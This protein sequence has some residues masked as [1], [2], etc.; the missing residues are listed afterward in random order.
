MKISRGTGK[1]EASVVDVRATHQKVMLKVWIEDEVGRFESAAW[2][3]IPLKTAQNMVRWIE[4]EIESEA[5][6]G[7][8]EINELR[9]V[10]SHPVVTRSD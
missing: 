7:L 8:F 6:K 5:Q 3:E 1:T 2:L 9:A 4:A 10:P